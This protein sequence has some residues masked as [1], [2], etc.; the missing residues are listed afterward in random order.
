MTGCCSQ[1]HGVIDKVVFGHRFDS[2]VLEDC[3]NLNDSVIIMWAYYP[4]RQWRDNE[5]CVG[6]QPHQH[7]VAGEDEI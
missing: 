5:L 1:C 3:F 2:M 4:N 6:Q 7:P